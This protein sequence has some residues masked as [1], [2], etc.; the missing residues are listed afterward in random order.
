MYPFPPFVLHSRMFLFQNRLQFC[1]TYSNRTCG[2]LCFK[3][4]LRGVE[5]YKCIRRS[6]NFIDLEYILKVIFFLW[7]SNCFSKRSKTFC[8]CATS[9]WVIGWVW[10]RALALRW[11]LSA[12]PPSAVLPVVWERRL[13][14]AIFSLKLRVDRS[15][16]LEKGSWPSSSTP[17]LGAWAGFWCSWV[18]LSWSWTPKL[19]WE[20][21]WMLERDRGMSAHEKWV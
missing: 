6:K 7:K 12:R 3:L 1:D 11:R 20:E 16:S 8:T 21:A 5:M 9:P 19:G 18:S 10:K 13:K 17:D 2:L 14:R 15:G 4:L